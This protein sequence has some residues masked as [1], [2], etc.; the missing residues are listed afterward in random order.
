MKSAMF[1]EFTA[2][3]D[4]ATV[5]VQRQ[6]NAPSHLVWKAWTTPELLDQW[7]A[8]RPYRT[9]T[10][11]MDFRSGG[12]WLYGMIGPEG[13]THWCRADYSNVTPETAYVAI[14]AFCDESGDNINHE[15]GQS[16]WNVS[17][18]SKGD[19]TMVNIIISYETV[20]QMHKFIELGFKEG[21]TMALA[22]LDEY[23]ERTLGGAE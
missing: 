11:E 22:N 20:D 15:F 19:Q 10:K 14:D 7:W 16:T 18:D 12:F 6:F 4:S 21:F 1:F 23:F 9:E 8:P 13:D 3:S 2:D 17:F 5:R